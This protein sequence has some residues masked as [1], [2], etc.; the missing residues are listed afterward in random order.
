MMSSG[1]RYNVTTWRWRATCTRLATEGAIENSAPLVAPP[2]ILTA[3]GETLFC[4]ENEA[5]E[6]RLAPGWIHERLAAPTNSKKAGHC[7][8][9]AAEPRGAHQVNYWILPNGTVLTRAKS[10]C[11]ICV[12]QMLREMSYFCFL[13]YWDRVS[14]WPWLPR[15]LLCR[16]A[17]F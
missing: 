5:K 14:M 13:V 1:K 11:L 2:L 9:Q 6:K 3:G 7:L 4:A 15:N 16:Q 10:Q 12:A 8:L 17:D